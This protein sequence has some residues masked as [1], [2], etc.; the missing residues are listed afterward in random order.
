MYI[1][2]CI[3]VYMHICIYV[4]RY[5][6]IYTWRWYLNHSGFEQAKQKVVA[7]T[8]LGVPVLAIGDRREA[9]SDRQQAIGNRRQAIGNNR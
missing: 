5:I 3:Y 9:K 8:Q 1:C 7:E 2:I 4:Y 6:C